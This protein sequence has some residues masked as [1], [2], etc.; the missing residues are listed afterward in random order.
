MLA[1]VTR[2]RTFAFTH[3]VWKS[4]EA[5]CAS[6][7]SRRIVS[8]WFGANGQT[9]GGIKYA[10][11]LMATAKLAERFKA[12]EEKYLIMAVVGGAIGVLETMWRDFR[13]SRVLSIAIYH[14]AQ[15]DL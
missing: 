8:I 15:R 11:G 2:T 6:A 5:A 3:F 12:P 1:R 14:F 13:R 10:V 7:R 4:A 9:L